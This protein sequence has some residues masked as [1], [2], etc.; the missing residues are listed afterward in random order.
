[1]DK[2]SGG[3]VGM[4]AERLERIGAAMQGYVDRGN[5]QCPEFRV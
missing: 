4:S 1:M 5:R 3:S 2:G